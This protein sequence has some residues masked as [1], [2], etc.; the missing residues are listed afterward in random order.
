MAVER[1]RFY[2]KVDSP[3]P[4]ECLGRAVPD[5][6]MI[7]PRSRSSQRNLPLHSSSLGLRARSKSTFQPTSTT[8]R[9]KAK[10]YAE[11]SMHHWFEGEQHTREMPEGG[12]RRTV[13]FRLKPDET[14]GSVRRNVYRLARVAPRGGVCAP[15][16]PA[17]TSFSS[18]E[19]ELV[20]EMPTSFGGASVKGVAGL[21][22]GGLATNV[23]K[24]ASAL[25]AK[26]VRT[27]EVLHTLQRNNATLRQEIQVKKLSRTGLR[28]C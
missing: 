9:F 28:A 1:L 2:T 5:H 3:V 6:E 4:G 22:S 10:Q 15:W 13:P 23:G 14:V 26:H 18:G 25:L 8:V 27:L 24:V 7:R 17:G 12:T 20:E 19:P 11:C 16:G 21:S